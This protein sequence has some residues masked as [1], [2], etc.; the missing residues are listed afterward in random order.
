MAENKSNPTLMPNR[1][2]VWDFMRTTFVAV[3]EQGVTREQLLSPD[4]WSHVAARAKPWDKIEVLSDDGTFYGE[5]LVLSC[6]RNWLKLRELMYLS[7]TSNDVSQTQAK[8]LD[9]GVTSQNDDPEFVVKW[10]GPVLKWSIIRSS[11]RQPIKEGFASEADARVAM[12]EY[13]ATITA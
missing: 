9:T 5:Y 11:D 1:F 12:N 13:S 3:A 2:E 6:G 10:R 4:Y 7:L 8:A